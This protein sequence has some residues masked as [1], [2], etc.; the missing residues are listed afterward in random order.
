M[1]S[2]SFDQ[3]HMSSRDLSP[4]SSETCD[5]KPRMRTNCDLHRF[6]CLFGQRD[7]ISATGWTEDLEVPGSFGG[8]IHFHWDPNSEG[9]AS[10][11]SLLSLNQ[12]TNEASQ[13]FIHIDD[14]IKQ[15]KSLSNYLF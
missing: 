15:V 13:S 5:K 14:P 1:V 9:L 3:K 7:D 11:F 12:Y 2:S 4:R 8:P 10:P 6:R